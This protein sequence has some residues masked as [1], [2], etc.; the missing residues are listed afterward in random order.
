MFSCLHSSQMIIE[1]TEKKQ[2][3]KMYNLLP[4][5]QNCSISYLK[6]HSMFYFDSLNFDAINFSGVIFL[7]PYLIFPHH[8]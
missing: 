3:L 1:V 8:I 6:E 7:P 4:A 5:F 2:A